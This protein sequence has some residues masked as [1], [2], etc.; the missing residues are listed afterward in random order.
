M[1]AC[2]HNDVNAALPRRHT[3]CNTNGGPDFSG[4]SYESASIKYARN[5]FGRRLFPWW[6]AARET[7]ILRTFVVMAGHEDQALMIR[8]ARIDSIAEGLNQV[9]LLFFGMAGIFIGG[10]IGSQFGIGLGIGAMVLT[11]VLGAGSVMLGT[12]LWLR[13]VYRRTA[14]EWPEM[15]DEECLAQMSDGEVEWIAY[16][17]L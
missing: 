3:Y 5:Y 13:K 1:T 17:P 16:V 7:Q 15:V 8:L 11:G 2:L 12:Q 10:P 6:R 9:A 14:G 4:D